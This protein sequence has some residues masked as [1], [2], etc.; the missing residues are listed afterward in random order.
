MERNEES[1]HIYVNGEWCGEQVQAAQLFWSW[2]EHTVRLHADRIREINL[3]RI[4]FR[5]GNSGCTKQHLQTNT[6]DTVS[7]WTRNRFIFTFRSVGARCPW[8]INFRFLFEIWFLAFN[9]INESVEE[10]K[11]EQMKWWNVLDSRQA[12]P[13]HRPVYSGSAWFRRHSEANHRNEVLSLAATR[14]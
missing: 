3:E 12:I 11:V 7:S 5:H 10:L 9:A 8:I 4:F 14:I 1:R 2:N 6:T 13:G